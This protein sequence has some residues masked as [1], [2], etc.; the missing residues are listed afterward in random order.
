MGARHREM[1]PHSADCFEGDGWDDLA[2][3]LRAAAKWC[4]ENPCAA[5][6]AEAVLTWVE[7]DCQP[8]EGGPEMYPV[9]TVYWVGPRR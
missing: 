8:D 7:P 3:V 6:A 2:G 4:D 9:F 1:T 5:R